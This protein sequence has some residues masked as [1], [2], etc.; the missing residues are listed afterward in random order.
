[1]N[2]SEAVIRIEPEVGMEV[3]IAGISRDMI[4]ALE[5]D[6]AQ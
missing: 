2:V 4:V 5:I 1:V 3:I 6:G